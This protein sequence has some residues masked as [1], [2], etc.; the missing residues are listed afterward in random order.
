MYDVRSDYPQVM[1]CSARVSL[2][3]P[4][5]SSRRLSCLARVAV[6]S[7]VNARC[8]EY[9]NGVSNGTAGKAMSS[10]A[11]RARYVHR[12]IRVLTSTLST[13]SNAYVGDVTHARVG[14]HHLEIE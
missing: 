12:E 7:T 4:R 5:R 10:G 1:S 3:P 6:S 2:T 8:D 13:F 14:R 9:S 11:T